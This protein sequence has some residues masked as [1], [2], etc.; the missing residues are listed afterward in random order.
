M[1]S[2]RRLFRSRSPATT[3]ARRSVDLSLLS[4]FMSLKKTPM[5]SRRNALIGRSDVVYAASGGGHFDLL[6]ALSEAASKPQRRWVT[7]EGPRSRMLREGGERV[8][9]LPPFDA[10]HV[11][12][13]NPLRSIV[14]ALRLRPQVVVTSGAGVVVTFVIVCWLLGARVA[15]LETMARVF[16]PSRAGSIVS[17]IAG[18]HVVQWPELAS[19][20][21]RARL[22]RP[23]LLPRRIA[24]VPSGAGTFVSLGTHSQPHD[25]LL[26]MV[27]GGLRAGVLPG[28]C[29][30]QAGSSSF[31]SSRMESVPAMAPAEFAAAL[32]GARYIVGHCG[33]GFI[34]STLS[35]GRRPIIVAR[36]SQL[37]EHVDDHQV[38]LATRL[39][40]LG[41]VVS[42]DGAIDADAA[43][44]A[45]A[46]LVS[47]D[48][49]DGMPEASD[50]LRSFLAHF[51]TA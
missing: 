11:N 2:P 46:P 31:R 24:L 42:A 26:K 12:Y 29:L 28:P 19:L 35:A 15:F 39:A 3:K 51:A 25:R 14:L 36:R 50:V 21:P 7:V 49:F 33:A 30:V 1:F 6:F 10:A 22:C 17:R 37:G 18:L 9:T 13:R 43:Q 45:D 16:S 41:L 27:D 20:F 4:R 38:Q 48:M 34:A 40:D 5:Q 44:A 23:V 8:S 47:D 32:A